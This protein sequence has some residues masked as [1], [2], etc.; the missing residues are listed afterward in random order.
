[1]KTKH[2]LSVYLFYGVILFNSLLITLYACGGIPGKSKVDVNHGQQLSTTLGKWTWV[3]GDNKVNQR[4]VYG[5]KGITANANKPSARSDSISWVDSKGNLWLFGGYGYAGTGFL[6]NLNDLW[7]FDGTNWTWVSGD[8]RQNEPGVYNT[9]GVANDTNIPGARSGSISWVDSKGDLFL[10]GGYGYAG[11][12]FFGPLN[13]LWKFDG[14]N[15]I[16]VSGDNKVNQRGVYGTKGVA[17][18]TNKPGA[19]YSSVSWTDSKG[20]LWLLGGWGVGIIK[21]ML[22]DDLW[23]FDGTNWTW[24]SGDIGRYQ[25]GVYGTKGVSANTNKPGGRYRGISWIDSKGNLWLFGG[26]KVSSDY[27]NDLW[28]FEP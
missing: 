6:G 3:S 25:R 10:F 26:Q 20:N 4:G 7:K 1:M 5:T 28:K 11:T 22:L 17:A 13:D 16:W 21:V 27:F 9:M 24:V 23:K 15:W 8:T 14:T 18:N 2:L 12:R 19:R